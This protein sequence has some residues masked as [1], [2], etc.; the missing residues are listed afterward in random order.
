MKKRILILGGVLLIIVVVSSYIAIQA[1]FKYQEVP[2]KYQTIQKK[3]QETQIFR[4]SN[5]SSS[6]LFDITDALPT[7]FVK[8][9][10][11][12]YTRY[13]QEALNTHS[14]V[15]FPDFPILVNDNGIDVSSNSNL[16]FRDNSKLFLKPSSKE[17]YEILRL[18]NVK[19]VKIINPVIIGDREG[20]IGKAGEWGMGIAI[21]SS[22]DIS[23]EGGDVNKC[24][25]DGIYIG[26]LDNHI[27]SRNVL[28]KDTRIDHNRR[29]GIA[30]VSGKGI[31]ISSVLVSN[32]Q[33]TLP[34]T[35]I[36]IEPS[37]NMDVIDEILLEN[38]VTYNNAT[39]GVVVN[40]HRLPNSN[41][42]KNS[43]I[44]IL[45]HVDEQ[46]RIGF[47]LSGLDKKIA[48][49]LLNG[50]IIVSGSRLINNATP[51]NVGNNV[52]KLQQITFENINIEKKGSKA[53]DNVKRKTRSNSNV[54]FK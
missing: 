2:A 50:Q 44:Q 28:V 8:D 20:H 32:T 15:V 31:Y 5:S 46:S 53:F 11:V 9:G 6:G 40:L 42:V 7:G 51:I 33:G 36:D 34:M 13:V 37:N 39:A 54:S 48:P 4:Q 38:V 19:N 52:D 30:I 43:N 17:R 16:I 25:G 41:N 21:R 24:W 23:I 10:S 26:R 49:L 35:G 14:D 47:Y 3:Y 12:D 29:N 27:E 1:K 18:H 45:N 22:E